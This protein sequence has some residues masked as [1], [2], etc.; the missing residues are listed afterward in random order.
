MAM[1]ALPLPSGSIGVT[2]SGSPPM[3]TQIA[4]DS[5]A[6][7][8][9]NIGDIVDGVSVPNRLEVHCVEDSRILADI[10][11]KTANLQRS[12]L[13]TTDDDSSSTN[14]STEFYVTLPPGKLGLT[15]DG[16][17]QPTIRKVWDYCPVRGF[18]EE[19][20]W[21]KSIILP[22]EPEISC[23]QLSARDV[24]EVL[25]CQARFR[26]RVLVLTN[27]PVAVAE[28]V[29]NPMNESPYLAPP[30][31][32]A[33]SAVPVEPMSV[34]S[35]C[36]S[37]SAIDATIENQVV[38]VQLSPRQ[39]V[40][41]DHDSMIYMSDCFRVKTHGMNVRQFQKGYPLGLTEFIYEGCSGAGTVAFGSAGKVLRI[42][43]ED[44]GSRIICQAGCYLCSEMSVKIYV[45]CAPCSGE[46]ILIR[47]CGNGNVWVSGSGS[48]IT[49]TLVRGETLRCS[50][51]ALMAFEKSVMYSTHHIRGGLKSAMSGKDCSW[52]ELAGPGS[53]WIQESVTV[54]KLPMR[55]SGEQ[56]MPRKE[57]VQSCK[58]EF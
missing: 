18:V 14:S 48:I 13:I 47:L 35:S 20:Q 16:D 3:V 5:P 6:A 1:R 32:R 56:R 34:A 31:S 11:S 29:L 53:V 7:G 36:C 28:P 43:L 51:S 30:E 33:Y 15:F 41:A 45:E 46:P 4:E 40:R 54:D 49:K 19:G 52:T 26:G 50:S 39:R 12:L 44:Y 9:L 38:T 55:S 24:Y 22:G 57:P 58:I 10:L 17:A 2:F 42:K 37:A 8:I 27:P 21:L 25:Q 23:N